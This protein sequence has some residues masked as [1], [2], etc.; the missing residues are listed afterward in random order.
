MKIFIAIGRLVSVSKWKM[1]PRPMSCFVWEVW[2]ISE[3]FQ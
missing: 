1:D 3:F 2:K